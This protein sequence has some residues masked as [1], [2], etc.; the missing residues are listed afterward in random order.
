[1]RLLK[2]TENFDSKV[3]RDLEKI[4]TITEKVDVEVTNDSSPDLLNDTTNTLDVD[5]IKKFTAFWG[6]VPVLFLLMKMKGEI[7]RTNI[8]PKDIP[9]L[10][11]KEYFTLRFLLQILQFILT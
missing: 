1:M 11:T 3:L 4:I 7:E 6:D 9:N 2:L 8:K 10:I 5:D